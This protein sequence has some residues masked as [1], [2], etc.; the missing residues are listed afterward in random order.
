MSNRT[1]AGPAAMRNTNTEE[2]GLPR[3]QACVGKS[4]PERT[5]TQKA[6]VVTEFSADGSLKVSVSS[7]R[8]PLLLLHLRWTFPVTAPVR[9]LGDAFERTYGDAGWRGMEPNRLLPWYILMDDG[10]HISAMGVKVRGGAFAYWRVDGK[11]VSLY[12]DCR[13]G[14]SGVLPKGRTIHAG[15]VVRHV[16]PAGYGAFRAARHFCR[17]LCQDPL[18]VPEPVYGSNNWYYAYGDSTRDSILKDADIVSGLAAEESNRPFMVIDAGWQP[19]D[20]AAGKGGQWRSANARH[21]DLQELA[22]GIAARGCKPGIWFRPLRNAAPSIPKAWRAERDPDFL[23]PSIPEVLAHVQDDI[24]HLSG[25]G[26]RLLKHDFSTYDTLGQWGFEMTPLPAATGNWHL[27]D[28]SRTTAEILGDFYRA[29]YAAARGSDTLILGCNTI[30]H[31]SAGLVH[32]SRIGDDTSGREW[33]RTL[34][35]GVNTLAFRLPQHKAFFAVDADCAGITR[36]VDW[37]RNAEWVRLLAHSGTPFFASISPDALDARME[38][39]LKKAMHAA[40]RQD[41]RA[42]PVDWQSSSTPAVWKIDGRPTVFDWYPE[43]GMEIV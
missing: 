6:D 1:E 5:R 11:G 10:R 37:K 9:I 3:C 19:D 39:E 7:R 36:A 8:E 12:L 17:M 13:N 40:A 21:G 27:A 4:F 33:E 22:R 30:G 38:R 34:K 32:L 43:D 28:R 14:A 2:L 20:G 31:L 18:A 35:M 26:Y 16:Y 24:R 25:C 23:D 29:I 41:F 15:D 42:E